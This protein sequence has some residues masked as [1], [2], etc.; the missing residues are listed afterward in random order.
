MSGVGKPQTVLSLGRFADS[1]ASVREIGDRKHGAGSWAERDPSEFV[2]AMGRHLSALVAG[3]WLDESGFPHVSHI[4]L[5]AEY[6]F[7]TTIDREC[8]PLSLLLRS[9]EVKRWH[10]VEHSGHPQTV[11]DHAYRVAVMARYALQRL[12]RPDLVPQGMAHAL[13]HDALEALEGDVPSPCK[14]PDPVRL[15]SMPLWRAVVKVCDL[16]DALQFVRR[17]GVGPAARLAERFVRA[18]IDSISPAHF[19]SLANHLLDVAEA[20][21]PMPGDDA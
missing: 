16:V 10:I 19:V 7:R 21:P 6:A 14:A 8:E 17:R 5:N 18:R 2:E 12:G 4:A 20:P 13:E 3:E 9:S 1:V 15:D 11:A